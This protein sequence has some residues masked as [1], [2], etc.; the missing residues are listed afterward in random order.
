[1]VSLIQ[2]RVGPSSV[3][4]DNKQIQPC[5]GTAVKER[6]Q[7]IQRFSNYHTPNGNNV[8]PQDSVLPIP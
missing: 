4:N 2:D 5:A 7:Q 6:M 1:M 3:G 8:V